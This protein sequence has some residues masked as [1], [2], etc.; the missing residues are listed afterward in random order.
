[1]YCIQLI[2]DAE[3]QVQGLRKTFCENIGLYNKHKR[4]LF[5]SFLEF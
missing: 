5:H 1:M 3:I 4:S 2:E